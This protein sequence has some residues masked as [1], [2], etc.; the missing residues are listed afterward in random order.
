VTADP[1]RSRGDAAEELREQ[2]A[3]YRRL[4]R[5]ARTSQG[6]NALNALGEQFDRDARRLDPKSERL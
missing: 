6:A 1:P 5:G 3:S 4:A 2:A